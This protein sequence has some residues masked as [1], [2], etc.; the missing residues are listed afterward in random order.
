MFKNSTAYRTVQSFKFVNW[1]IGGLFRISI[2]GFG[3]YDTEFEIRLTRIHGYAR[4]YG[5]T[6]ERLLCQR[7]RDGRHLTRRKV[8]K[9]SAMT[10]R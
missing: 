7:S 8:Q 4:G 3:I 2:L 6:F 10:M 1:N 9:S 5:Y